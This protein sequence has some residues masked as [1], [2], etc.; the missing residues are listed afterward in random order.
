MNLNVISPVCYTGY[1]VAGQNLVKSLVKEGNNVA[2][3]PIGGVSILEEDTPIF[4]QAVDNQKRYDPN[5]HCVRIWHQFQLDQFVG[6]GLH[7]GYPIFELDKFNQVELHHLANCDRLF[8]CSNWAKKVIADSLPGID[9]RVVPLGVNSKIFYPS[10]VEKQQNQPYV[11]F[12]AGKWEK[13]KGHDILVEIFNKA[14]E[15]EDDVELWMMPHN[16]FLSPDETNNWVRQY[17]E[18]K[19]GS[20]IHILSHCNTHYEVAGIM[21]QTDCG[22]FP[23]RAEGWNLE[24]LEMM[25]CGKPCIT[26]NYSAHTEFCGPEDTWLVDIEE[27]E[28]ANDGKWFFGQGSWAKMGEKQ[29]DQFVE[30]MRFLYKNKPNSNNWLAQSN[31]FTWKNSAQALISN[32]S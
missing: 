10:T 2:L 24:L 12:N 28:L 21:R 8:V 3:W 22:I 5:A 20:K 16:P 1:G 32:L 11:F 7:I 13:R 26:T 30:N 18:S 23:S 29:I 6:R 31:K 27:T 25:A 17:K 4:Q 15:I 19:L 9:T 14:F